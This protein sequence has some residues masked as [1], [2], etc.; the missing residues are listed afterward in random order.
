MLVNS[1]V[2]AKRLDLTLFLCERICG[3]FI[4]WGMRTIAAFSMRHFGD[5]IKREWH[6]GIA[7]TFRDYQQL[8]S[9]EES[10]KLQAAAAKELGPAKTD[11]IDV[12]FKREIATKQQIGDA[13]DLAEHYGRNP[14]S[15]W[16]IVHG[17][18]RLSQMS[19]Y[20]DERIDLDKAA[21][22]VLD[23]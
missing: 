10:A 8:S 17:L 20:A 1:E 3:N 21:A 6:R 7:S 11:V 23:F 13:Y 18:T 22:R 19:P 12:L 9:R 2:G 4:I 14:R 5:R 16:G 15:A